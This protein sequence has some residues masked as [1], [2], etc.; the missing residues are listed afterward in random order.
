MKSGFCR[1]AMLLLVYSKWKSS[2]ALHTRHQ[3][4]LFCVLHHRAC[5]DEIWNIIKICW[6]HLDKAG[7]CWAILI[8]VQCLTW[9][10]PHM[11]W[12]APWGKHMSAN[13]NVNLQ[14]G[15]NLLIAGKMLDVCRWSLL[16][17]LNSSQTFMNSAAQLLMKTTKPL[18]WQAWVVTF[19]DRDL[20][21]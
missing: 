12:L 18:S 4:W 10:S 19:N 16:M 1:N 21:R 11:F 14:Q 9:L 5:Q 6:A 15:F 17:K 20:G 8:A 13:L 3:R 7:T 2:F